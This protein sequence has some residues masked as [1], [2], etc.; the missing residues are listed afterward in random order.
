MDP[1]SNFMFMHS[2]SSAVAHQFFNMQL[3]KENPNSYSLYYYTCHDEATLQRLLQC[4]KTEY[5]T[6]INLECT[7]FPLMFDMLPNTSYM[8]SA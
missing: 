4:F 3:L 2:Y 8:L 5:S 6:R 1:F 7:Y